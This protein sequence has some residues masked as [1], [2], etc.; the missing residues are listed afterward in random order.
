MIAGP[1]ASGKSQLAIDLALAFNG[2]VVNADSMQLYADL[3]ILTARPSAVDKN[4]VPHH[5]YGILDGM[6]RASVAT[7]LTLAAEAMASIRARGRIPIVIGGTGMYLNAAIRGI[8]P[9][10]NVPAKIHDNT[11]ALYHKI[12]GAAFRQKLGSS[13]L[14]VVG[15]RRSP[16]SHPGNRLDGNRYTAQ[17]MAGGR[18][19]GPCAADQASNIAIRETHT[20]ALITVMTHAKSK[21]F[22]ECA[23][24]RRT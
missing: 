24:P 23:P 5:L 6:E 10:P 4:V 13:T 14:C 1:T 22:E 15:R 9:I 2:E 20:D 16:T 12:G 21:C 7:W 8:A 18:H 11:I 17:Q 3:S 19:E